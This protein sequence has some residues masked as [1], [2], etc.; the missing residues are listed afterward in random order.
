MLGDDAEG[1]SGVYAFGAECE[2]GV[3]RI[4]RVA[5]VARSDIAGAQGEGD[6]VAPLGPEDDHYVVA[7]V[8]GRELLRACADLDPLV[9]RGSAVLHGATSQQPGGQHGRCDVPPQHR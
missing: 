6:H 7:V 2:A 1:L 8:E 5:V 9:T 3:V 4:G